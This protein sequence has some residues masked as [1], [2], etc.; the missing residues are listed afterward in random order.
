[1]CF[2]TISYRVLERKKKVVWLFYM[3]SRA[4]AV[5]SLW[6]SAF[7][8]LVCLYFALRRQVQDDVD[9]LTLLDVIETC[10]RVDYIVMMLFFFEETWNRSRK[11]ELHNKADFD[12]FLPLKFVEI[13]DRYQSF[14]HVTP[15]SYST[16]QPIINALRR[17]GQGEAQS[18]LC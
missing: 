7:F 15:I 8:S 2:L 1:M 4:S 12:H 13:C 10:L 3:F 17:L 5:S 9:K 14:S 18:I 6:T 16:F 11:L